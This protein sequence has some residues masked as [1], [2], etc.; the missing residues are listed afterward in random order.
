[1]QSSSVI[2][3]AG[4]NGRGI[5]GGFFRM[6]NANAVYGI[7][8]N[9][10]IAD[11]NNCQ[12]GDEIFD[13]S[14]TVIGTLSHWVNLNPPSGGIN[15]VDIALL[16]YTAPSPPAWLLADPRLDKP[17]RFLPPIQNGHVYMMRAD[18]IPR[19]GFI[20]VPYTIQTMD[21]ILDG[22]HFLFTHLIE[23]TPFD[24]RV[25]SE[26]GD[27]GS[28]LLSSRDHMAVGVVV[29]TAKGGVKSYAIPFVDGILKYF[30][31]QI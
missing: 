11:N 16:R 17:T 30:P 1:M 6:G 18:G 22:D 15:L 23:I 28:V 8:N 9:H 25:F 19:T 4:N 24:G 31:L 29:G 3:R 12:V 26:P 7:S 5:L 20:S 2:F 21:L 13:L 14:R 10:V 27:S